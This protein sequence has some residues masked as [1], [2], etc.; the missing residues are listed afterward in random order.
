M[1]KIL[2]ED[3]LYSLVEF[4][5]KLYDDLDLSRSDLATLFCAMLIASI[6]LNMDSTPVI[7]GAM[8][9]SPLMTPIIGIGFSLAIL[10]MKLLRKSFKIL[11]IQVFL[12]LLASTIYFFIS[13]ISYASS[14]IISRT[15][16]TIWD[17]VIAFVGGVAGVIGARKKEANNI[18]PGVAIATAL[19]PPVCTVGYAIATGNFK[20]MLG[21]SY[22]FFINCSFIMLATYIGTSFTMVK[23]HY[24]KH[25]QEAYKMRKILILVSLILIIPSLV[26]A[27]T[28]V[29]E[30]LINESINKYLSEQ[31]KDNTILKKNYDKEDNTLKLTISG[32]YLS[33]EEVKEIL[34]KQN[35]YGLK[36]ISIQISQLS[37]DRLTEKD[38][39]EY[40]IQYKNDHELQKIDKE[41]E[42][43]ETPTKNKE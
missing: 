8:L 35:D 34:S 2:K 12:S 21:A 18:V 20:F 5:D 33:D 13:P 32:N 41:K 1:R 4:R 17:I 16:P 43:K 24:I 40:I 38:I 14:E 39:V 6:G 7:I 28:L 37:N 15:S 30:T 10:D 26:S 19:M 27:T 3:K 31:F 29:R 9:I 42:K 36:N 25:N 11:S 23:N 22:L